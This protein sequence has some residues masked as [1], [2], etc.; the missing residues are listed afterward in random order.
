MQ[1]TILT[2]KGRGAELTVL[3]AICEGTLNVTTL[4]YLKYEKIPAA[5]PV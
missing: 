3:R 2:L 4:L 5:G 1:L